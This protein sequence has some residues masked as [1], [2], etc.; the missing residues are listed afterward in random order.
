MNCSGSRKLP[1]GRIENL[2]G[3]GIGN[4]PGGG[5]GNLPGGGLKILLDLPRDSRSLQSGQTE[6]L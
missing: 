3:G 6:H 1:H 4:M 2:P 5:I